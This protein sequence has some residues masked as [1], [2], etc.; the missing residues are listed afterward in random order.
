MSPLLSTLLAAEEAAQSGG[1]LSLLL[2]ILLVGGLVYF[3]T[4][5]SRKQKKK[6]EEMM[7]S[8][9]V[10]DEVVT[11]GG[12]GAPSTSSR[13]RVAHVAIDTDVVIRANK[14]ALSRVTPADADADDEL[15][16]QVDDDEPTTEAT[17]SIDVHHRG[18]DEPATDGAA[19]PTRRASAD[20]LHRSHRDPWRRRRVSSRS[21]SPPCSRWA[22]VRRPPPRLVPNPG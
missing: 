3:M 8:L 17:S 11:S 22:R 21:S 19:A 14:S 12:I 18:D 5:S 7:S 1:I 13:T 9:R 2:M 16:H 4:A 15:H 20:W 6:Q 10:G